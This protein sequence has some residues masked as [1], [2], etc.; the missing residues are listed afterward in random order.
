LNCI[1]SATAYLGK[2]LGTPA[3]AEPE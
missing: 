3:I 2:D 1:S